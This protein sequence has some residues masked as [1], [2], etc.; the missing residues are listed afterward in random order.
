MPAAAYLALAADGRLRQRAADAVARLDACTLCARH[1]GADRIQGIRRAICG[2]GRLAK[3]AASGEWT[4]GEACL[5]GSAF[6][7]F[8]G[9]NLRC[10]ACDTWQAS[11]QN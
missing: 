6:I 10:L 5:S 11:W 1:C 7:T 8:S 4:D 3:V 2:I 9:C